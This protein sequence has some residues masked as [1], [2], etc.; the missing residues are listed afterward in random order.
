MGVETDADRAVFVDPAGFGTEASYL[1]KVGSAVSINGVWDNAFSQVAVVGG[2]GV[3]ST[4]PR[5][6]VRT[7]DLPGQA[8]DGDLIR[9]PASEGD[10]YR[11]KELEPDETGDM[12]FLVLAKDI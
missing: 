5:F 10:M 12:T 9:I 11:V 7:S 8:D 4:E 2:L 6:R 3:Q 1:P